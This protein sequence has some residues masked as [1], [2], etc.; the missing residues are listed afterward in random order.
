LKAAELEAE[1]K[2][3][4]DVA[5]FFEQCKTPGFVERCLR[6]KPFSVDL[7]DSFC[8]YA[9]SV[10]SATAQQY[11]LTSQTAEFQITILDK[12]IEI[13]TRRI[14]SKSGVWR[15]VVEVC[16]LR[17]DLGLW[18]SEH[19]CYGADDFIPR[20]SGA[21]IG[22]LQIAAIRCKKDAWTHFSNLSKTRADFVL[23]LLRQRG[24]TPYNWAKEATVDP[25]VVYDYL[26]NKTDLRPES[27]QKLAAALGVDLSALPG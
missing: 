2:L 18:S 15:R 17:L 1:E 26:G 13:L 16:A 7:D 6:R 8:R 14:V 5:K 25:G 22:A 20:S 11:L 27:A 21:V 3:I 10:F 24:W 4:N 9:D 12:L 19:G 23:P